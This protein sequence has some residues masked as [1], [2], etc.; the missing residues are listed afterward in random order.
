MTR[1]KPPKDETFMTTAQLVEFLGGAV[2]PQTI[3][4]WR[5]KGGL[6]PPYYRLGDS[7]KSRV[8]Y[9][10][11]DIIAWLEA[12]KYVHSADES[13]RSTAKGNTT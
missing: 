2:K 7:P 12:R 1:H 13:T 6:G 3:R 5:T 4:S 11:S 8:L 9:K 10:L